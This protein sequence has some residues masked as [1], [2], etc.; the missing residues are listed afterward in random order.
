MKH[1]IDPKKM[2]E[3]VGHKEGFFG[4]NGSL[5]D[6]LAKMG[7][8]YTPRQVG[9]NLTVTEDPKVPITGMRIDMAKEF[10]QHFRDKGGYKILEHM[11]KNKNKP[12]A[13]SGWTEDEAQLKRIISTFQE[14]YS[15]DLGQTSEPGPAGL[16]E[17][18][19]MG[20]YA[21]KKGIIIKK[22][23]PSLAERY[24]NLGLSL[25]AGTAPF[26]DHPDL[27]RV[28]GP[29]N[30]YRLDALRY[31]RELKDN[32]GREIAEKLRDFDN[33]PANDTLEA[34]VQAI[35]SGVQ[36][37]QRRMGTIE[38]KPT[39]FGAGNARDVLREVFGD[40]LRKCNLSLRKDPKEGDYVVWS[41]DTAEDESLLEMA[42]VGLMRPKDKPRGVITKIGKDFAGVLGEKLNGPAS[43]VAGAVSYVGERASGAGDQLE[44]KLPG[45][46]DMAANRG[47]VGGPERTTD[48]D[49]A[50]DPSRFRVAGKV[51]SNYASEKVNSATGGR[52][53][54]AK[55][56][57]SGNQPASQTRQSLGQS[58]QYPG[59][60]KSTSAGT[61]PERRDY[62]RT[63]PSQEK[64]TSSEIQEKI[65]ELRKLA[66]KNGVRSI[67]PTLDLYEGKA[68]SRV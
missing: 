57:L 52:W 8:A 11:E 4:Q 24:N 27:F 53:E 45:G 19:M 59:A 25:P 20:E 2:K 65:N 16:N 37:Y 50:K 51:I 12:R 33:R 42:Y 36:A 9:E 46:P 67:L 22:Q 48:S 62:V 10:Y 28:T 38:G 47:W 43:T 68:K 66:N 61:G 34:A 6:Q 15:G 41:G 32:E 21:R 39:G 23:E 56:E 17:I 64:T 54:E 30:P 13:S 55:A 5:T 26:A 60:E 3:V 58:R 14:R 40:N 35:N 18:M 1:G 31:Q 49:Q 63:A 44:G 29:Y 7:Y